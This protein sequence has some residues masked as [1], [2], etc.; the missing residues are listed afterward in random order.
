[1][2]CS[3]NTADAALPQIDPQRLGA[4]HVLVTSVVQ[5]G[6]D[7]GIGKCR[8][9]KPFEVLVYLVE[10]HGRLVTKAELAN[11]VWPNTTVMDATLAQSPPKLID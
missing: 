3:S 10:Q 2:P 6:C 11:A 1:M 9:P 7:V 4:R 5:P 8:C